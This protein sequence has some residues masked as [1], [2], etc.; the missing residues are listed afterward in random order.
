[1]IWRYVYTAAAESGEFY[2]ENCFAF[3]DDGL[4]RTPGAVELDNTE[5]DP[6]GIRTV[7]GTVAG[8]VPLHMR[9]AE[10][11]RTVSIPYLV[12]VILGAPKQR[13]GRSLME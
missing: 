1:M 13:G 2:V 3:G 8:V 9:G 4:T 6:G 10:G 5:G 11:K 12:R 7:T